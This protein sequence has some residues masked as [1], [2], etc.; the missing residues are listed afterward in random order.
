M[1]RSRE[2]LSLF[3]RLALLALFAGGLAAAAFAVPGEPQGEPQDDGEEVRR[4]VVRIEKKIACDGE[5]CPEAGGMKMIFVDA[6]GEVHELSGDA[7]HWIEGAGPGALAGGKAGYLGVMMTPMTPELRAHQGAPEEAGVL[8]SKVVDD[9]PAWRAGVRV[10]DVVSAVDG[11]PVATPRDLAHAVRGK[12]AGDAVTLELWRGGSVQNL[13]VAV[14]ERAGLGPVAR[15]FELRC[16]G[17]DCEHLGGEFQPHDCGDA[18]HCAVKVL[19]GDGG[20]ECTVNGEPAD[21]MAIH[22]PHNDR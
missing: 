18:E 13:T 12:K 4:H 6:E 7:M 14:E 16:E 2:R 10:G 8:V 17:G 1:P 20:C 21:C 9:S 15:R 22:G 11:E 3:A 5:D 19:C